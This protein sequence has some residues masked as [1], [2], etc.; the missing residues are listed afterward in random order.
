MELIDGNG[1]NFLIETASPRLNGHRID[2]L[3]QMAEGIDYIQQAGIHAPGH[4]PAQRH[5]NGSRPRQDHRLRPDH[6]EHR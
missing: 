5:G 4:L 6:P 2:F 3:V 1:L